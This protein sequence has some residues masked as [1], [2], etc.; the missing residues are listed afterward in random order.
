[1]ISL[2]TNEVVFM[3]K[4]FVIL[5][6]I[7]VLQTS[8]EATD[9]LRIAVGSVNISQLIFPLAQKMGF[10]RDE[11]LETESVLMR[12]NVPVAALVNGEI[13]YYSGI[14]PVVIAA[15]RGVPV[16]V[17]ACYVPG[18]PNLLLARPEIKS[19]KELKGS[20]IAVGPFGS[21]PHLIAKMIVKQS[22]LD[23]DNDVKLLS[24]GPPESRFLAVKQGLAAAAVLSS[25]FDYLGKKVGF[26]VLARADELFSYPNGGLTASIKT[27]RERP[28]E[29]KHVIKAGIKAARYINQNREGTIQVMMEWLKIDKEMAAATYESNSKAF[30]ADGSIPEDGLRLVIEEAKTSANVQRQ[31]PFSDVADLTILKEVQKELGIKG[32]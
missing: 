16:K 5:L 3:D 8:V 28:D 2:F 27:I 4:V 14:G 13:D 31:V 12:G 9:K 19:L 26:V 15:I 30:S 6:T 25:P 1:V 17:V 24:S 21:N 11:G 20:T 23:P 32:K 7:L 22:G 18:S 29:I 10:L